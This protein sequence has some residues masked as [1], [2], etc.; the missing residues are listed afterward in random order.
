[1]SHGPLQRVVRQL[2]YFHGPTPA[3]AMPA[4]KPLLKDNQMLGRTTAAARIRAPRM[5][6]TAATNATMCA[7][8]TAYSTAA[9]HAGGS[10]Y[11]SS[12]GAS[13]L[14]TAPTTI[15]VMGMAYAIARI[16][17]FRRK[18]RCRSGERNAKAATAPAINTAEIGHAYIARSNEWTAI[19][20][21]ACHVVTVFG[22]V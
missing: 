1:M 17:T 21:N 4:T 2:H 18:R 7:T 3:I 20:R 13:Y 19:S 6:T 9:F 11:P 16:F 12:R 22:A 8:S 10:T 14:R 15:T 5:N